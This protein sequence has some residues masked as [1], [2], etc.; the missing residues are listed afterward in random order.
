MSIWPGLHRKLRRGVGQEVNSLPPLHR[1]WQDREQVG[2]DQ[3]DQYDFV[4]EIE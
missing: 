4:R 3:D 1:T 2:G